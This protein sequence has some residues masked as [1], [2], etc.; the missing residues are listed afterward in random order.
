MNVK[1]CK[2]RGAT[3][4][5]VTNETHV[6]LMVK[7]T[8]ELHIHNIHKSRICYRCVCIYVLKHMFNIW[9]LNSCL[10]FV[11]KKTHGTNI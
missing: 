2:Q 3:N 7:T 1:F 10:T 4:T 6:T 8:P 5:N 11:G 9:F